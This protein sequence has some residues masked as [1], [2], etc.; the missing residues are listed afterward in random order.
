[1]RASGFDEAELVQVR[2][3][4]LLHDIGKMGIPDDILHKPAL[5]ER[6]MVV[7]KKHPTYA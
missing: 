2:W 4:A 7:M 3:G 5:L 6:R 1:L